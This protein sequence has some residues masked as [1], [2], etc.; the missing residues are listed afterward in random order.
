MYDGYSNSVL[1]QHSL[2][3][4][5]VIAILLI[6][7]FLKILFRQLLR[8]KW[9]R[10]HR[11]RDITLCDERRKCIEFA[12]CMQSVKLKIRHQT[13]FQW[14]FQHVVCTSLSKCGWQIASIRSVHVWPCTKTYTKETSLRICN[15]FQRKERNTILGWISNFMI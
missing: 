11:V 4:Q 9:W 14:A 3:Y 10:N 5:S 12:V 2:L 15:L 8:M 7:Y 6:W 13:V 1:T